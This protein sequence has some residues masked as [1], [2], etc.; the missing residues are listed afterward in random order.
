MYKVDYTSLNC[1][2]QLEKDSAILP[3]DLYW[4]PRNYFY[5]S[6]VA[7]V[8]CCL[9]ASSL[10]ESWNLELIIAAMLTSVEPMTF[11]VLSQ[12][13][14]SFLQ[15]PFLLNAALIQHLGCR[16]AGTL[17]P[18]PQW[19]YVFSSALPPCLIIG[20]IRGI[21]ELLISMFHRSQ[22]WHLH[23]DLRMIHFPLSAALQVAVICQYYFYFWPESN[24]LYWRLCQ[25]NWS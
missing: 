10:V 21:A 18:A 6:L 13:F 7:K 2:D 11:G 24:S 5:A 17:R 8:G 15:R 19:A 25:L 4:A 14:S 20:V 3:F 22:K 12:V 9:C 23:R 16:P 1:L